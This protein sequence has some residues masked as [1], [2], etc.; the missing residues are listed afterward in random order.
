MS[1]GSTQGTVDLSSGSVTRRQTG[2]MRVQLANPSEHP[3][4]AAL[5]FGTR[6]ADWKEPNMHGVLGLHR[7][8]V[9][10]IELGE[11][12]YVVKELPDPL[13]ER[14]YRLLRELHDAGLPTAEVVAAVTGKSEG[15]LPADGMLVTRHI[16]YALPYRTLL[17]GRGLTIPYLGDRSLLNLH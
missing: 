1:G 12:S 14:E 17:S 8:V 5:P 7:H 3:D 2:G 13:V 16:D 6:L 11:A 9:R 15:D 10:L 4:L